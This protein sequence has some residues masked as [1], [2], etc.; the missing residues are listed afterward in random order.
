MRS[1]LRMPAALMVQARSSFPSRVL[2]VCAALAGMMLA[3]CSE[4]EE[5]TGEHPA[6]LVSAERAET[7]DFGEVLSYSG[8][9]NAER[10]VQLSPRVDGLVSR[11]HVD[12]GDRVQTGQRLLELDPEVSRQALARTRA[13]LEQAKAVRREAERQLAIARRLGE[14]SIVAKSQVA[15]RESELAIAQAAEASAQATVREQEE[16]ISRHEVPAPFSGIIT[17]R[18]TDSGAWV[19]RGTFVLGLVATDR[20][21]LDLQVPQE[22]FAQISDDARIRVYSEALGRDYLP[23]EAI[24]KVPVVEEHTRTF[25]LRLLVSDPE[26]RLLPGMSARAEISIPPVQ[27]AIAISRDALLRQADGGHHVF[28]IEQAGGSI[29]ARRRNVRVLYRAGDRVA[30]SGNLGAG[31]QVIVQGNEALRDGQPVA[32]MGDPR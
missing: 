12:A 22:R 32:I 2:L 5:E 16:L 15:A 13:Q 24:A 21:R 25:L 23:G 19:A 7:A 6:L 14:S 8:S 29:A 30:V 26:A 18:L 10:Q 31:E 28:V 11:V 27:G 4:P 17:E 9:M 20:I 1:S 3:A